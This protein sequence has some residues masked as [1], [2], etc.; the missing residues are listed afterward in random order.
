MCVCVCVVRCMC[1]RKKKWWE[2]LLR[3]SFARQHAKREVCKCVWYV[4]VFHTTSI[5]VAKI[6]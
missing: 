6:E 1:T 4:Q 5:S 2:L 3:T